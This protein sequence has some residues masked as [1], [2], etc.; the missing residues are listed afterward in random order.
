MRKAVIIFLLGFLSLTAAAQLL[1]GVIATSRSAAETSTLLNGLMAW[2]EMDESSGSTCYDATANNI[3]G[4][5]YG[6]ALNSGYYSFDG[7]NDYVELGNACRP[8][9]EITISFWLRSEGAGETRL[10]LSNYNYSTNWYGYGVFLTSAGYIRMQIADGS[11]TMVQV[12]TT[13]SLTGTTWHHVVI[14]WDG[15]TVSI[16]VNNGATP[17]TGSYTS[18]IAYTSASNLHFGSNE[19]GTGSFYLGDLRKVGIWN[20]D[21]TT[22]EINE[23][24]T[25]E[26][27]W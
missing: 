12:T 8:T 27:P 5:I 9:D 19:E 10:I 23:L 16:Y 24:Y 17:T 13:S 1:P 3:D 6:A 25:E 7:T 26:Y 18:S 20:R 11:G 21:I 4:T 14:T 15:S 22:D 2:W